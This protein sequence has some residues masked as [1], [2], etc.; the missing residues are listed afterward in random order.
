[1]PVSGRGFARLHLLEFDGAQRLLTSTRLAEAAIDANG[2]T[3]SR[4]FMTSSATRGLRLAIEAS[5]ETEPVR[6]G[7][8]VLSQI[9]GAPR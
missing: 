7:T 2:M 1:L 6:P 3:L 4:R 8:P 5:A 9:V